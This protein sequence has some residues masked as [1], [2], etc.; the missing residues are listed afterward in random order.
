MTGDSLQTLQTRGRWYLVFD[1]GFAVT[2]LSHAYMALDASEAVCGAAHHDGNFP[3]SSDKTNK[4]PSCTDCRKALGLKSI[5][6]IAYEKGQRAALQGA[7]E[8]DNP[9]PDKRTDSGK[10]T[11]SRAIRN[12]WEQGRGQVAGKLSRESRGQR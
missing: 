4:W 12:S 9:Y 7:S 3:V 5:T 6:R 8:F 2:S 10:V 11:Y 1:G